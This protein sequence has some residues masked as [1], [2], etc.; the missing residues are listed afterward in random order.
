MEI[1]GS[2]LLKQGLIAIIAGGLLACIKPAAQPPVGVSITPSEGTGSKL[3]FTATFSDAKGAANITLAGVLINEQLTRENSCYVMFLPPY[4][5]LRLVKDTG[6]EAFPLD[7]DGKSSVEN[8]QCTVYAKG[9]SAVRKGNELTVKGSIEFK[10]KFHGNKEIY[11]Y[12]ENTEGGKTTMTPAKGAWV[13][14]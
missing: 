11:L 10:P 3:D 4:K 1:E 7:F 12:A 14:P 8:S 6:S 2:R 13:V 9:S 5:G